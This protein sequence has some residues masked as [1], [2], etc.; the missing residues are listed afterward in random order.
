MASGNGTEAANLRRAAERKL[1]RPGLRAVLFLVLAVVAAVATA[2]LFRRYVDI[3]TAAAKVPTTPVVVA[4]VDLPPATTL[5]AQ[6]LEV[7]EWPTASVPAGVTREPATLAGR[8]VAVQIAKGE[9]ILASRL[10]ASDAGRGLSAILPEGMRAAAVRVDDVVGVAGFI[11]PGDS[12]DVIVT[13]KPND[14]GGAPPMSK[15]ILQN[16]T[17]IA[18]GKEVERKDRGGDRAM[19][20]TVATL[21]VNSEQS[22]M[23]ALA[24]SKG[25]L[26]L[27]L[28]NGI[29]E[30]IVETRGIV[31]PRLLTG[32]VVLATEVKTGPKPTIRRVV[33]APEPPKPEKQVVEILRGDL[34]ER[35]DFEKRGQP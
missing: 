33:R 26:L 24:A 21:M 17:V 18:V 7:I 27:T 32:G 34:F 31:P 1:P 35:R 25:Q 3:R 8:V 2:L 11:H 4:A 30:E 5:R 20:A 22:E 28:R 29:D 15:I 6:A 19:P 14:G 12:V 13:M 23:L 9:P 16:I 10:A